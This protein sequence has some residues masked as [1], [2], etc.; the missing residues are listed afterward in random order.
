[1]RP[2]AGEDSIWETPAEVLLW[3]VVRTRVKPPSP[4]VAQDP[5]EAET[6]LAGAEGLLAGLQIVLAELEGLLD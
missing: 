3:E 2:M 1:M 5:Q 4:V 6:L